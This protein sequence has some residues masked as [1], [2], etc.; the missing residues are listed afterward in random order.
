M[1]GLVTFTFILAGLQFTDKILEEEEEEEVVTN[2][3]HFL[4]VRNSSVRFGTT[5][6]GAL[7][8]QCTTR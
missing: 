6:C 5:L 8:D 3:H 7:R 2:S 1:F 4:L